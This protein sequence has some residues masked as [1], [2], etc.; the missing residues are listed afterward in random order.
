MMVIIAIVAT[1]LLCG[2]ASADQYV[3]GYTRSDG[4]YVQ[5]YYRSSPDQYRYNNYSSQGN[6]NPYTGQ[7]GTQRNEFSS[8]PAYNKSNP[9][10]GGYSG[11]SSSSC[12][13]LYCP[14]KRN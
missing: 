10:G 6:T 5:G 2:V 9:Y 14:K 7:A 13:G 11:S 3:N 8:P 12:Y 1:M 4:T